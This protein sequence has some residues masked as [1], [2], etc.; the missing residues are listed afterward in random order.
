MRTF[1]AIELSEKTRAAI[2]SLVSAVSHG[3]GKITWVKPDRMHLTLKFLGEI[4]EKLC[5]PITG[6]LG[7]VCSCAAPF[8]FTV[9][10]MGC[11]P[12]PSR[13]RVIW[14]GLTGNL[15]PLERLY[16]DIDRALSSL[17]FEREK[18]RFSPHITIGRVRGAVIGQ[19]LEGIIKE[20]SGECFG[21]EE[22]RDV[23]FMQSRLRPQG[24]IYTPLAR[25]PLANPDS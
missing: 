25:L 8:S 18:R 6:A 2:G 11:F 9:S 22:V 1:V 14:V 20:R 17:G 7:E 23:V 21:T 4:E 13:P 15:E 3:L 16:R 10:G 12:G 5:V 19:R 24:P